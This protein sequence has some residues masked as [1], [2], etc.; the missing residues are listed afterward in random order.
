M[1]YLLMA[2]DLE[3]TN[4]QQTN[5]HRFNLAWPGMQMQLKRLSRR[6]CCIYVVSITAMTRMRMR[7]LM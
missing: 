2:I 6:I 4:T 3:R 5:Q 1:S 7:K